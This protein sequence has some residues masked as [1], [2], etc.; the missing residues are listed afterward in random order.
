MKRPAAGAAGH[1]QSE[2]AG[3][4]A[5]GKATSRPPEKATLTLPG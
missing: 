1:L 5:A 3:G 4:A 2:A